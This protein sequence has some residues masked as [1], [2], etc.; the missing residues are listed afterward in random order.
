MSESGPTF[1]HLLFAN[2]L[3]F[4]TKADGANCSAIYPGRQ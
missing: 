1:S 2:D 4:F 3:I